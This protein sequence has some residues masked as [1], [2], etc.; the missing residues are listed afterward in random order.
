[1]QYGYRT[2]YKDTIENYCKNSVCPSC[3]SNPKYFK[4]RYYDCI[5]FGGKTVSEC[6]SWMGC[7]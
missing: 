4:D 7:E 2:N 5:S 1:M 6:K 3:S